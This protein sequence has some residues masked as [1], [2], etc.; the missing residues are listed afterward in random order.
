MSNLS[1]P[2]YDA[3]KTREPELDY[4]PRYSWLVEG[5]GP[6]KQPFIDLGE[7]DTEEAA[8]KA[9]D[10]WLER[11]RQEHPDEADDYVYEVYRKESDCTCGRSYKSR[12]NCPTHGIDPDQAYEEMRERRMEDGR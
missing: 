1:L 4:G 3:W 2:G 10:A 6:F 8:Q 5:Y 9:A 11:Q 12:R 7:F